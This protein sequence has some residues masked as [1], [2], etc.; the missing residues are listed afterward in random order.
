MNDDPQNDPEEVLRLI[1]VA[2]ASARPLT[3]DEMIESLTR[4][5]NMGWPETPEKAPGVRGPKYKKTQYDLAHERRRDLYRKLVKLPGLGRAAGW[6]ARPEY[7]TALHAVLAYEAIP[8][9]RKVRA[10]LNILAA[11]GLPAPAER[12]VRRHLA[13]LRERKLGK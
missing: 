9:R 6:E 8:D 13:A 3:R 11:L 5:V 2:R 1:K 10:V 12:T 4:S 7:V